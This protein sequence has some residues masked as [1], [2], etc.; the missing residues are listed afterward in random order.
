MA[1]SLN[2]GRIVVHLS[3]IPASNTP[4]AGRSD[5][6]LD[7]PAKVNASASK[8][9]KS[10]AGVEDT[11]HG[12]Q[13]KG[14][15]AEEEAISKGKQLYEEKRKWQ[16][17]QLKAQD[18]LNFQYLLLFDKKDSTL[19]LQAILLGKLATEENS[20]KG[21]GTSSSASPPDF[22]KRVIEVEEAIRALQ[23]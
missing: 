23:Y 11:A 6:D 5:Q 12:L 14:F 8:G 22:N 16:R 21:F 4:Q 2:I 19:E 3:M 17:K 18:G 13:T 7:C 20:L 9:K 10:L 15:N 1:K